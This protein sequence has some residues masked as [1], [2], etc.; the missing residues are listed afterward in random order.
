[1]SQLE[2]MRRLRSAFTATG[3]DIHLHEYHG[4]HDPACWADELPEVLAWLL[5]R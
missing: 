2:S 4:G 1:M 3:H 5:R